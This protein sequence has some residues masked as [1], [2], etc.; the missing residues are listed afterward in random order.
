MILTSPWRLGWRT[1]WRDL[2]AGELRLL[3]V[4]VTLAVAALTAVGFF[5]DRL[6]GGLAR[7]ARQLLGGDAVV[8][9]DN[10]TPQAFIDKARALG[11]QAVN[12]LGFPTMARAPD[13]QGGASR[14]VALKAVAA[15]LSG[16]RQPQG[17]RSS[18]KRPA[19][20]TREIP[21]RGEA[22]VD[23]SLLESLGL[24]MGEPLLLGDSQLRVARVIVLEPD[25]G[26]GFMS[27]APR[28]M[29]NEADLPAS[30]LIQPASR[31]SYRFAVAGPDRQ[32]GAFVKWALE[33]VKKPAV[34]GVRVES[35]E[36]GRPEMRQTLDRAEKFLNLVALLAALLSAVAVALAARGFAAAHL[37]DC[38]ML[39]VMGQSQRT[40]AWS[41]AFEFAH[42]RP[43]RQPAGRAAR[44]RR[45]FRLHRAAGGAG[46]H[47]A[48]GR[49]ALAGGVRDRHGADLAV[50]LRPAA[51]A[52]AGAGA[53]ACV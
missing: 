46:G 41:Y 17:R 53:A 19:N 11:L 28:V 27:F 7:D 33:E 39:R 21:A 4:A 13:A 51:G 15:G 48:A 14:L 44:L 20:D 37:D 47:G 18:R 16:A 30:R 26:A 2:R 29:V 34:R 45:A 6:K 8:S 31:V 3:I 49:H 50:R 1:L 10:P 42:D 38:A 52:A 12:T 43:G 25:R 32:V 9:S 24:K 36:G 23:A 22:W 40:I 5:A 35:L